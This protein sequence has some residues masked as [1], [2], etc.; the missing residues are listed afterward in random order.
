MGQNIQRADLLRILLADDDDANAFACQCGINQLSQPCAFQRVGSRALLPEKLRNFR[1]N[2]LIAGGSFAHAGEVKQIKQLT[3]GHPIICVVETQAE[4][5]A[6]LAAGAAD[7]VLISQRE[8]LTACLERHLQG[9][10]QTPSFRRNEGKISVGLAK[11]TENKLEEIDRQ[12]GAFLRKTA[13]RARRKSLELVCA[14]RFH[15][16]RGSRGLMRAVKA[17]NAQ[18]RA[19]Q[20][21]RRVRG[22]PAAIRSRYSAE[23]GYLNVGTRT[24]N[25]AAR[26]TP[27]PATEARDVS[28]S[29]R[30]QFDSVDHLEGISP[31]TAYRGTQLALADLADDSGLRALELSFK[32]LFHTALDAMFL[33]DGLGSFLHVNAAGCSLLGIPAAD[34]LGKSLLDFVPPNQKT[35]ASAFWEALLIEG[36]QK[37]EMHLQAKNG[38]VRDVHVSARA[39]LW[40]GVHLLVARDQTELR[41]L[42]RAAQAGAC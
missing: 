37:A 35:H 30:L 22:A 26:P 7:C 2:V 42:Q 14:A 4:A 33:L 3:N 28:D 27:I 32:T 1:P 38:E 8:N 34:L 36:Q 20:Q 16:R 40:F 13:I 21:K 17:L 10:G 18:W 24:S 6:S 11:K 5:E 15:A 31:T 41:T 19:Y 12:I 29:D 25:E 23:A 9:P 39:N